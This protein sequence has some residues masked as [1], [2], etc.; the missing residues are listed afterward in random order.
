M[1]LEFSVRARVQPV[2]AAALHPWRIPG[3]LAA[4]GAFILGVGLLLGPG[5]GSDTAEALE[6]I[7]GFR[8]RYVVTNAVDLV[9]VLVL[10]AGLL[11]IARLQLPTRGSLL[12]LL[13]GAATALGGL[14]LVLTLVLQS[15][16]DPALAER[17]V[18]AGGADRATHLA[19]AEAI[20]DLDAV[21]FGVGFLL[22]MGGIALIAA[23]ALAGGA[24]RA[25]RWLL[26]AGVVLAA[27]ASFTALLVPFGAP[28]DYAVVESVLGL[29]VIAWLVVFG[30]LIARTRD[31]A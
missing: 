12:A 5:P 8:T 22:T 23:A 29:V 2:A 10:V 4:A 24:P 30:T 7:E 20:F 15:A 1:S 16:V 18:D 31:V 3:V 19:V 6:N 13:G 27:G 26:L 11:A 17:Y 9:G 14:M 21:V 28:E 25:N